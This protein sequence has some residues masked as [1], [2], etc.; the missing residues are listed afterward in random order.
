M[1]TNENTWVEKVKKA[2]KIIKRETDMSE[3][4]LL[5][6]LMNASPYILDVIIKLDKDLNG[7]YEEGV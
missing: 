2:S 3:D 7:W 4:V 6:D 5:T 1:T